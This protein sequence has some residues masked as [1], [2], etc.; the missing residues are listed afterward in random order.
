MITDRDD[1]PYS[2]DVAPAEDMETRI[3]DALRSNSAT[4]RFADYLAINTSGTTVEVRGTVED[5]VDSEHVADVISQLDGVDEV[6]DQ[7]EVEAESPSE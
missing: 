1:D 5:A 4:S 3:R 2:A 7:M 6:V